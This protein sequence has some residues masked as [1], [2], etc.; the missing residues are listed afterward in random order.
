MVN[1]YILFRNAF[2]NLVSLN[3]KYEFRKQQITFVGHIIS[4][5][6]IQSDPDKIKPLRAL[7]KP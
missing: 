3:E 2:N 1:V 4:K 5:K 7:P 6:R